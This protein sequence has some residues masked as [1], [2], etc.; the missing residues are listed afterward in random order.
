MSETPQERWR[1]RLN[2]RLACSHFCLKHSGPCGECELRE[3]IRALLVAR[4][5]EESRRLQ[6]EG[7]N[8]SRLDLIHRLKRVVT[9]RALEVEEQAVLTQREREIA[10][11]AEAERAALRAEVER[12]RGLTSKV[13]Y[14]MYLKARAEK[15]EAALRQIAAW[16]WDSGSTPAPEVVS[17]I[18]CETR[19]VLRDSAPGEKP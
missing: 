1:D 8:E 7:M 12:L 19:A 11:A 4:A 2:E 14:D 15:A 5:E 6:L 13:D 9:E 16:S 18:Y 17:R 3:D 10:K